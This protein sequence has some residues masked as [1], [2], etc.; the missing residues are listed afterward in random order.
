MID[1]KA[2]GQIIKDTHPVLA[3]YILDGEISE[4]DLLASVFKLIE[5]NIVDPV[6][7]QNDIRHNIVG[8]KLLIKDPQDIKSIYDRM[9]VKLFFEGKTELSAIAA[10]SK[11]RDEGFKAA[12]KMTLEVILGVAIKSKKYQ[13]K[14]E[15]RYI[16]MI[17]KTGPI[18]D[19]KTFQ[20]HF[21]DNHSV[22]YTMFALIIALLFNF[23]IPTDMP[24]KM[25]MFIVIMGM[26]LIQLRF[27]LKAK[28]IVK[29][30]FDDPSKISNIKTK[31]R[32]LFEFLSAWP[33]SPHT[34]TNEFL[35]FSI[36]FGIDQSWNADF[37]LEKLP[38]LYFG[39]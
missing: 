22:V 17:N 5:D 3:G 24:I 28:P 9:I 37:G 33:L 15:D 21:K 26:L 35:P 1:K 31:Y 18:K 20:T 8:L 38:R 27:L 7:A 32:E 19:E 6:F 13:Y 23:R 29:V 4:L 39:N 34:F 25:L 11:I 2:A 10:G 30:D 16:D 14:I 36:A 12:A